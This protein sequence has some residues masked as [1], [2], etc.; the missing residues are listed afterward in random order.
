MSAL[1][2]Y[3]TLRHAPLLQLVLGRDVVS[4][5]GVL[6]NHQVRWVADEPFPMIQEEVGGIATGLVA[7]DITAED[8]ARLDFY[9][10]AFGYQ[11]V[12]RE[13]ETADGSTLAEVYLPDPG[14]WTPG[15]VWSL[16]DWVR[17]WG[18]LTLEAA[19]EVMALYGREP[20]DSIAKRFDMIRSR[21]QS[22][23]QT[24][25]WQRPRSIGA[26]FSRADVT[27]DRLET[28]YRAFFTLEEYRARHRLFDGALSAPV[29]RAV[30]R[31]ADAVTV[32]PYDPVA[33]RVLMIEQLRLGAYAHG[34]TTPWLLEPIAGIIDAGET[35]EATARRETAEEAGLTLGALHHAGRYYPSPGGVAQVLISYLGI[36]DLEDGASGLGGLATEGEDIRS[37]VVSFDE[38]MQMLD[39]G[40]LAVAPLIITLQWLAAH[41]EPL[42]A[43][44]L[45]A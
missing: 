29:N 34:D 2:F 21:A 25:S 39:S 4:V 28:P 24:A 19:A 42:R 7:R 45:T 18:A 17:D 23:V 10:G 14:L 11:L 37:H 43:E 3:G 1:F 41:R 16:D 40:E 32:L 8:R 36:A 12:H 6:R 15:A 35:P 5:D 22:R 27:I 44:S 33:D 38:A 9:E 20:A 31:A 26:D 30:F 13:V